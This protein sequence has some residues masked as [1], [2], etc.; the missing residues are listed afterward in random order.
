M[1]KSE[2]RG[3]WK[4]K[5][6]EKGGKDGKEVVAKKKYPFSLRRWGGEKTFE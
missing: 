1:G 5:W 4:G 6:E 2:K 3:R